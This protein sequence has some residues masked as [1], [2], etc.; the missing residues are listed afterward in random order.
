MLSN[1]QISTL[2]K[3]LHKTVNEKN[4]I[5]K[6]CQENLKLL[7]AIKLL[8][9]KQESFIAAMKV[10]EQEDKL[11]LKKKEMEISNLRKIKNNNKKERRKLREKNDEVIKVKV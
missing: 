9:A 3:K 5:N 1:D 11:V 10:K 2:L 8:N 4:K 7:N 6:Q